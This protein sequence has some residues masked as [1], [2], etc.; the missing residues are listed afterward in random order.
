[1]SI[2]STAP[3]PS[4]VYLPALSDPPTTIVEYLCSHFPQ[5]PPDVWHTRI[6]ERKVFNEGHDAVRMDSPY[7][8]GI[9]VLYFRETSNEQA[10]PFQEEVLFEN[11][12]LLVADKPHFLPVTPSGEAVNECLLYRLQRKTGNCELV[13][14][15]RLDR[16]TAGIVLFSKLEKSRPGYSQLFEE[17]LVAKKYL[18]VAAVPGA[19]SVTTG[20]EWQVENRIERAAS[21]FRMRTVEGQQNAITR[22]AVRDLDPQFG[23]F[24]LFPTTGKKHQLRLHMASIGWPILNDSFYPYLEVSDEADFSRPLQLLASEISF[25]DPVTGKEL[26]FRSRQRLLMWKS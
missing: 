24:E 3:T 7:Q 10:I 8:A 26:A 11:E 16:D 6:A 21:G 18:A 13:P 23:Y 1:M 22:I 20:R 15:H 2:R 12:D 5:I 25:K 17:K 19:H 9:T 14:L 4:K